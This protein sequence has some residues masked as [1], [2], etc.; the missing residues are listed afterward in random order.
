MSISLSQG[1]RNGVNSLQD[2]DTQIFSVN[3]RLQT[4]KKVNSAL[5]NATNY[6]L[7]KGYQKEGRDLS[8]LLDKMVLGKTQ[9]DKAV[10]AVEGVS[11]LVESAQALA[12]TGLASTDSVTRNRIGTE[13]AGLLTQAVRLTRDAQFAGS[14][15]LVADS[16]T[17]VAAGALSAAVKTAATLTITTSTDAANATNVTVN[18]VDLRV[19]EATATG[20]LG[21]GIALN[22][23][24]YGVAPGGPTTDIVV[25][26]ATEFDVG[27]AGDTNFTNFISAATSALSALQ[28]RASVVSTNASVVDIRIQYTKDS[29]RAYSSAADALTLADINEEGA[30]LTS[31]QTRQQLAVTALSLASRSDQAILRLF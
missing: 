1:M 11:K 22:G 20:G 3:A 29:T 4:G 21:L 12:R 23:F 15:F 6:F 14:N 25:D 17:G 28:S 19:G 16:T 10:K 2:L 27:A 18:A 8:N 26:T 9:I 7:A 5:D 24:K 30:N 31:L 13:I